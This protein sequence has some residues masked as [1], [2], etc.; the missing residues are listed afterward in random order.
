VLFV[1]NSY[2]YFN[3]LPQIFERIVS[4]K[5]P[6]VTGM[7]TEGGMQLDGHIRSPKLE[8]FLKQRHW[9][10]VVLQEQS[11]LGNDF[12]VDGV[13]RI[14][15]PSAFWKSVHTL[16]PR[17]RNNG[18]QPVLYM[19][20]KRKRAPMRDEELLDYA[21]SEIGR[22]ENCL[23]APV[24]R[25]WMQFLSEDPKQELYYEDG[26][27]PSELGTYLAAA[28][29]AETIAHV[30]L[31]QLP[32]MFEYA[33]VDL[34]SEQVSK[35]EKTES[36]APQVTAGIAH[37]VGLAM[38]IPPAAKPADITEPPAPK[39]ADK[40]NAIDLAGNYSGWMQLYD[41]GGSTPRVELNLDDQGHG[42]IS[43]IFSPKSA[44]FSGVCDASVHQNVV[45]IKVPKA[46]DI[47]TL[48]FI[49]SLRSGQLKG[50]CEIRHTAFLKTTELGTTHFKENE[51]GGFGHFS[52]ARSR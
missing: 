11:T 24:G 12:S 38:Q 13:S 22:Q 4:T 44:G 14:V 10:Y 5:Q 41:T 39:G 1:G 19:T 40:I 35:T 2:T 43:I 36:L 6:V 34:E 23:V 8:T 50:I 29:L 32:Q 18:A 26:S 33:P 27:H 20:W 21:Y 47:A 31:K 17:I 30:D 3:N 49:G 51:L 28:T 25:A 42:I 7:L 48:V 16:V 52:L 37:A 46:P 15:D 45:T 9:D